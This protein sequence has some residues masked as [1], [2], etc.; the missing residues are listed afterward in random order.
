MAASVS[1]RSISSRFAG[2]SS[3][4][5]SC[6]PAKNSAGTNASGK[7]RYP[8]ITS[9]RS[10]PGSSQPVGKLKPRCRNTAPNRPPVTSPIVYTSGEFAASIAARS[11]AKPIATISAPVRLSGRRRQ[12]YRPVPMKIH[13]TAGWN[14]AHTG[15]VSTWSLAS[16]SATTPPP[17]ASAATTT[18][19][20]PAAVMP[21]LWKGTVPSARFGA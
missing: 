18:A 13:P 21:P 12:A 2:Q 8:A 16:I 17:A 19:R 1:S 6:G 11:Q 9:L 10:I 5:S 7:I 4:R 15:F 3:Q 20:I 14:T